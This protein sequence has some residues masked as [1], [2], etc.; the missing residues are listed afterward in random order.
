MDDLERVLKA[1]AFLAGLAPEHT[2][3]LV[4]CAKNVR[5]CLVSGC[6]RSSGI[7]ASR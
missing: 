1:H 2:T 5:W 6:V 4:S 7:G 3:F